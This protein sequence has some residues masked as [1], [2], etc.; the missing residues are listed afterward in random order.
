MGKLEDLFK[1][2]MASLLGDDVLVVKNQVLENVEELLEPYVRL[3]TFPYD[4]LTV[5]L[6]SP[7][8]RRRGVLHAAFVEDNALQ[9]D[10]RALLERIRFPHRHALRFD[11]QVVA[12]LPE[13]VAAKLGS[14]AALEAAYEDG[15]YVD[16]AQQE[17]AAATLTVAQLHR[18]YGLAHIDT[19]D[20]LDK[21]VV[22][23]GRRK[24]VQT[25][26]M[27]Y[28]INDLAFLDPPSPESPEDAPRIDEADEA[29]R[30]ATQT[31]HRRHAKI[32]REEDGGYRI[33]PL[34]RELGSVTV[35]RKDRPNIPIQVRP[36]VGLDLR[37]GDT[38]YLRRAIL[39]V[40]LG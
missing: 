39:R 37:D 3:K 27:G 13:E 18:E 11:V 31:V 4:R 19:L 26:E 34:R 6:F 40:E 24:T 38:I 23:L 9:T 1:R 17:A 36:H 15:F 30:V 5:F 12:S 33:F 25:G 16:L 35:C 21:E 7:G 28:H 32:V 2:K 22:F 14:E 8:D 20:M 29:E 10:L